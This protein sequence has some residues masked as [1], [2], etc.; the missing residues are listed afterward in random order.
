VKE[1][2]PMAIP[3]I[4]LEAIRTFTD[5]AI[6]AA[7]DPMINMPA[8]IIMIVRLPKRSAILPLKRDPII[9]PTKKDPDPVFFLST[10]SGGQ[11]VLAVTAR[12]LYILTAGGEIKT[13]IKAPDTLISAVWSDSLATG[14]VGTKTS[15][16]HFN[17]TALK[18]LE[19]L[20]TLISGKAITALA[21]NDSFVACGLRSSPILLF[22]RKDLEAAA[23]RVNPISLVHRFIEHKS[24]V[25]SLL[26][27]KSRPLLY[28]ASLDQTIKVFVY[29]IG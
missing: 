8:V 27:D 6:E 23:K 15:L 1:A 9:A 21:L 13:R 4:I 16:Y 18:K 17:G 5:G 11:E 26:F 25:T 20:D 3:I 24:E 22:D 14:Y 19:A 29:Y 7:T 28:S 2:I 12:M 10:L